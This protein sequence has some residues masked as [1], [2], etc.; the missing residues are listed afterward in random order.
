MQPR[1]H[2]IVSTV[3]K[4]GANFVA[5]VAVIIAGNSLKASPYVW[6]GLTCAFLAFHWVLRTLVNRLLIARCPNCGNECQLN[7]KYQVVYNCNH[8][9]YRWKTGVET[10]SAD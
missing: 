8:C 4:W 9:D 2:L 10:N 7:S 3:I 5:L 1:I 6:I